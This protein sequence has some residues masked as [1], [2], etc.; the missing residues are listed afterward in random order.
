MGQS[1][2]SDRP[3]RIGIKN[4]VTANSTDQQLIVYEAMEKG[5]EESTGT[6]CVDLSQKSI[7]N[8]R[9]S[10]IFHEV[11]ERGIEQSN[12]GDRQKRR[13]R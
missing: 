2:K 12:S 6:P 11:S 4:K 8:K 3:T 1:S 7:R 13:G 5:M 9:S 10:L